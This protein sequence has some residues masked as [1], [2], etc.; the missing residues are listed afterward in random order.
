ME[1]AEQL[2]DS[3]MRRVKGKVFDA[4]NIFGTRSRFENLSLVNSA[5]VIDKLNV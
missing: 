4:I 5:S 3:I 1:V 2:R